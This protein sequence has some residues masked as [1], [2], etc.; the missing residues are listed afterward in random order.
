MIGRLGYLAETGV[1]TGDEW[2]QVYVV[3][4]RP[5]AKPVRLTS[6]PW[7]TSDPSWSA[8]GAWLAV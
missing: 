6:N 5:E 3:E 2:E 1:R 7:N 8:D 4:A